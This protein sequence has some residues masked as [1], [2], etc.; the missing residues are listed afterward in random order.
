MAAKDQ[1]VLAVRPLLGAMLSALAV[2]I[3]VAVGICL[4]LGG[5]GRGTVPRCLDTDNWTLYHQSETSHAVFDSY[6]FSSDGEQFLTGGLDGKVRLYH[7]ATGNVETSWDTPQEVI[8]WATF[9]PD[10]SRILTLSSYQHQPSLVL[11]DARQHTLLADSSESGIDVMAVSWSPDGRLL[12]SVDGTSSVIQVWNADSLKTV[13]K[14]EGH[15]DVVRKAEFSPSG[16]YIASVRKKG[17]GLVST[18]NES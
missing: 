8:R 5:T 7:T 1:R 14:L 13:A 16:K 17:S 18:G 11:W 9:S 6:S 2:G 3:V 4:S 10:Q 15:T 12:I